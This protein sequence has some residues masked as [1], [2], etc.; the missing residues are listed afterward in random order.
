MKYICKL[1]DLL[2]VVGKA[3]EMHTRQIVQKV[4]MQPVDDDDSQFTVFTGKSVRNR[5]I[6]T[7]IMKRIRQLAL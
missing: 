3:L 1:Y 7:N 6:M 5:K 2:Q 4:A